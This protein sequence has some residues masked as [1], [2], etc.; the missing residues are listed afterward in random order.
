MKGD[1][2]VKDKLLVTKILPTPKDILLESVYFNNHTTPKLTDGKEA[3]NSTQTSNRI[4][5][6]QDAS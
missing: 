3:R 5:K 2:R 1:D 6:Y 4:N